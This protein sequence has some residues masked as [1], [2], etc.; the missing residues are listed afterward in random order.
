MD[1]E[2]LIKKVKENIFTLI[3]VCIC[4]SMAWKT[5][6]RQQGEIEAL[7]QT[8]QL[9][10]KKNDVLQEISGLEKN[11]QKLKERVNNKEITTVIGTLSTI[12]KESDVKVQYIKPTG[13]QKASV[14]ARYPFEL[15]VSAPSYHQ[16][17]KFVS[18]LENAPEYYSV[19]KLDITVGG[20]GELVARVN[21]ST[22]LIQ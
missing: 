1:I 6:Q 2:G 19:E 18:K 20:E 7:R 21:L 16:I 5:Y 12:A 8:D 11:Y 14:Y 4:A 22:I 13:E 3:V 10:R 17:G 9:E 15:C